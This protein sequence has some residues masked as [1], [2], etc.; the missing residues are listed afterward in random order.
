MASDLTLYLSIMRQACRVLIGC[1]LL[2][3]QAWSQEI[4]NAGGESFRQFG[5]VEIT[6]SSIIN[7][8]ARE[9]LPVRVL[10]RKEIER[11]G[12][13][14]M[15]Q[16]LQALPM[17]HSYTDIGT[18]NLAGFGG[19]QSAA[20]H[21]Y[22]AGTLILINGRRLA[23]VGRQRADLDRTTS[24]V[25][26]LPLS[27]VDR[28]EILSDGASSLYGSD[29][30][31]GVVNIITRQGT[32]GLHL[33]AETNASKGKGGDGRRAGLQWGTG[34][35]DRG[36]THVQVDFEVARRSAVVA[37]DRAVSRAGVHTVGTDAQGQPL[38][39]R[40]YPTAYGFPG[41]RQSVQ[42]NT[43]N[44]PAGYD[45]VV[46]PGTPHGCRYL[47]FNALTLYPQYE[48]RR[49]H[50]QFESP[51]AAGRT[52]Y[53]EWSWQDQAIT[54]RRFIQQ[55]GSAPLP[56]G[57]RVLFDL[58]P[59]NPNWREQRNTHHRGVLGL[60][61]LADTWHYN[62]SL[63]QSRQRFDMTDSGGFQTTN[64]SSL[65]SA[66]GPQLLESPSGYSTDLSS[67]IASRFKTAETKIRAGTSGL[68]ELLFSA[69][70]TVAENDWGD[71][72]LGLVVFAQRHSFTAE[73]ISNPANDPSYDT[74]RTNRGGAL[75]LQWPASDRLE[76]M[77][78]G[79]L[80]SYS[81]FGLVLTGKFGGKFK[82]TDKR[83]LRASM[84]TG[85]RAPTLAQMASYSTVVSTSSTGVYNYD[86]FATG[87]PD[88]KPEKSRQWS[89]GLHDQ[90]HPSWAW[91][92]DLWSL[93]TRDGFDSWSQSAIANDP[94]LFA[95]YFKM[96]NGRGRYDLIPFNSGTSARR[97]VDYYLQH[98]WPMAS[99][100]LST[101]LYGTH[102]MLA[103]RSLFPGGPMES[104]LGVYQTA[105]HGVTPR[106]KWTLSSAWETPGYAVQLALNYMSGNS[107]VYPYFSVFNSSGQYVGDQYT[108]QVGTTWT[109]DAA[110]WVKLT[111]HLRL[112]WAVKNLTD[113]DAPVRYQRIGAVGA[114][115][116]PTTDTRYNDYM[117]RTARVWLDWQL[118]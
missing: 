80:D 26:L 10:D 36:E 7:P 93:A 71:V 29:A 76:L 53:G 12:A 112:G 25:S 111:E 13:Q 89:V 83:Y 101:L 33:V 41:I 46:L 84:G 27:A 30:I 117:G 49:L 48:D 2:S 98:R 37:G 15:A 73:G 72:Q 107:E 62:F 64:W 82:L 61:G 74:A 103:K 44:C 115:Y 14:D 109:L 23:P 104:E 99:G 47:S 45:P 32:T 68:Q 106:N 94:A 70:S 100:R 69:S 88:L 63:T 58:D 42:G 24:D 21:G 77:A 78:A 5:Q 116:Y 19:Y 86:V 114:S 85:F 97:G 35:Q 54:Y 18:Y 110:G 16:L 1:T 56:E 75:E 118:W 9:A 11:S 90:T 22:E 20:I 60:K 38:Y 92:A 4:D 28:I 105:Y 39:F 108:H 50:A 67:I 91:G 65:L 81:D 43:D 40:P 51:L 6:G 96:I 57:D 31:A 17:M 66:Y 79:R 87:N 102:N 95:Q 113:R 8:R 34:Q 3:V 52:V 55:Q 59:L